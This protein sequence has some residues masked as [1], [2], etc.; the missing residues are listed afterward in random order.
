MFRSQGNCRVLRFGRDSDF[1]YAGRELYQLYVIGGAINSGQSLELEFS[2]TTDLLLRVVDRSRAFKSFLWSRFVVPCPSSGGCFGR[3][4]TVES[5]DLGG[6]VISSTLA[7]SY[8]SYTSLVEPSILDEVDGAVI[9]DEGRE[10]VNPR[11]WRCEKAPS[12]LLGL[13]VLR[14]IQ[15]YRKSMELLIQKLSFQHLVRELA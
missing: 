5:S 15:K 1:I 10:E 2:P 13:V 11:N 6:T 14:E 7:E 3:K 12:I 8:T 9:G 4:A